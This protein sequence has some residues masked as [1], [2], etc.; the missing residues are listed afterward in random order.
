MTKEQKEYLEKNLQVIDMIMMQKINETIIKSGRENALPDAD[1]S[2]LDEVIS[3]WEAYYLGNPQ[4]ALG[5]LSMQDPA[6][7]AIA[8]QLREA[9]N[10]TLRDNPASSIREVVQFSPTINKV[11]YEGLQKPRLEVRFKNQE[12]KRRLTTLIG[13]HR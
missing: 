10:A 6:G 4:Y 3:V 5:Y 8:A 2:L 13:T 11:E 1:M 9:Y 7:S 12:V